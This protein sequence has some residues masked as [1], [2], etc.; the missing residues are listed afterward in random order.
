[1]KEQPTTDSKKTDSPLVLKASG[2]ER[3][4][5]EIPPDAARLSEDFNGN[6]IS[7]DGQEIE[8]RSGIIIFKDEKP[9]D[10]TLAQQSNFIPATAR[11]YEEQWR[12]RSI[13][14]LS[15]EP[16]TLDDERQLLQSWTLP[17]KDELIL[18]LG[19]STAFY[20]RSAALRAPESRCVA[21]D[22]SSPML[23]EAKEKAVAEN[24][25]LFL[26]KADVSELPFYS[27]S[28]NLILCGGSLNEF[29][30]PEKVLYETRRVIHK[31]G[32]VFM[33]HLLRAGTIAGKI[34]QKAS[35]AGGISFW[36]EDESV[37]LF[38]RCGFKVERSLKMGVVMFSLLRP[39]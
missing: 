3:N 9:A 13:G 26:L 16:F 30:K 31:E 21:I 32:R 11:F 6:V 2:D 14:F 12:R 33:M 27:G 39:D 1:M 18:D 25:N 22:I 36:T 23:E 15:G 35:E 19:C 24:V 10:I 29:A 8:I 20:A 4:Y 37:A 34:S 5:F 38:N 17:E 7:A 28:A